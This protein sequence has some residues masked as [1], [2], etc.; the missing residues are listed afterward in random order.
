MRCGWKPHLPGGKS[1]YLF[2]E[3]TIIGLTPAADSPPTLPKRL[4]SEKPSLSKNSISDGHAVN[5]ATANCWSKEQMQTE[6]P[7]DSVTLTIINNYLVNTCREMGL[8][9]MKT[10]YSSIFNEGLDF[11]CVIFD[12]DGEMVAY[13]E[14]CPAQIGAILYTMQWTIAEIG[15]ENF[16]PGDVVMHNDPYRGGCHMPEHTVIQAVYHNVNYTGSSATSPMSQ[17]SVEKQLAVLPRMPR[18]CTKKVSDCPQ[19]KS[20][21]KANPL[22]TSG[23]SSS[24]TTEH[25]AP[26]GAISTRCSDPSTWRNGDSTNC[27]TATGSMKFSPPGSSSWTTR[28]HGCG[29]KSETSPTASTNSMTGSKMTA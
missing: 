23:K 22:R 18:R 2:L 7:I 24:K 26:L 13:A 20:S 28:R 16:K 9:M 4:F 1:V 21:E 15:L 17:R 14:F 12:R 25:R 29:Q 19:S 11:S 27:L 3:F 10:S 6:K 5:Y 8:A